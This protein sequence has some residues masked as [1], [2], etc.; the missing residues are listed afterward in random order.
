NGFVYRGKLLPQL[1]GKYVFSDMTTARFFYTDLNEMIATRGTRDKPA[2]IHELEILY[3]GDSSKAPAK[4][5][6][7]DIVAEAFAKK[8]GLGRPESA[9]GA[10]SGKGVLPG[11]AGV[12]GGW[13]GD[14]FE[15]GKTDANGVAYA[16]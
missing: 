14:A 11:V 4:R 5:R 3:K 10:Q 16:G 2:E 9:G 1:V 7:Y 6:M 15:A 13:R 12:P 8:G